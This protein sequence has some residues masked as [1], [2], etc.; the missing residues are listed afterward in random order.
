MIRRFDF[1]LLRVILYFINLKGL[2]FKI[3]HHIK[4]LFIKMAVSFLSPLILV[5]EKCIIC[6]F[7]FWKHFAASRKLLSFFG[8]SSIENFV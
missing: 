7:F 1:K 5:S 6:C 4:T 2:T 8:F 3:F